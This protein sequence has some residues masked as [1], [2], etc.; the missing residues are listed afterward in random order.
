[1]RLKNEYPIRSFIKIKKDIYKKTFII[2]NMYTNCNSKKIADININSNITSDGIIKIDANYNY[3]YD[4]TNNFSHIYKFYNNYQKFKEVKLNHNII[5]NVVNDKFD[6]RGVNSTKINLLIYLVNNNKN[7]KSVDL[8]DYN[9]VQVIYNDNIDTLKSDTNKSNISSNLEILNTNKSNISSNFEI[10]NTNKED[11]ASNIGKI[12]ENKEDI[13]SNLEKINE[14]K[15]DVL[16]LQNS[17]VKAF[18]NLDKILIYNI[19]KGDQ[20]VSENNHYHIFEK[21]IIYDFVK[22]SYLEIV[23]KVLTEI[24]N[25]V[26]IGF[27]KILCNFIMKMMIYFI[28]FHYQ[29]LWGVLIGYL[30][31]NQFLWFLLI[32]I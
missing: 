6:I 22:D 20:T 16:L 15:E 5:S 1:M 32:I 29:Q 13:A 30:P 26:I 27:L 12:D 31:L 25:Y 7:N 28:Q 14:N 8:F 9:T 23:L 18:Y 4:E 17:N 24:R 3:S 10:I 2:P 11:I 21:E 19:P